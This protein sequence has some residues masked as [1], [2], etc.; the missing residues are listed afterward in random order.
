[1]A[2]EKL[3]AVEEMF[4]TIKADA[5]KFYENGNNAAG[6]RVRVNSMLIIK[7]LLALRKDIQETKKSRNS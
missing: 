1:M 6:T 3:T 7:D 4:E 2:Q 5:Q